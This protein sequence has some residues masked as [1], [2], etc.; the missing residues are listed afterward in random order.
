MQLPPATRRAL[1]PR[2]LPLATGEVLDRHA[3]PLRSLRLSLTD[4]CNLRCSYCMPRDCYGWLPRADLLDFEELER[5]VAVF[6]AQGVRRLRL[7]GGE[8]LLRRDLAGLVARL[9]RQPGLEDLA[10]TTNG[11]LLEDQVAGLAAAGL[12]R[13]TVSLDTLVP[14]RFQALTRRD[15]HARVLRGIAAAAAAPLAELKLNVVVLRGF[16]DDELPDLLAFGRELG[17]EVRFIEYMDVGG[18]TDWR[19]ERVVGREELLA[20]LAA[21]LG[22]LTPLGRE[23]AAATATRF[24]LADGASFGLVTSTTAPFCGDCDR[25]RVTADGQWLRCLYATEALDLRAALRAGASEAELAGLIARVWAA[26]SDRGAEE[27]LRAAARG[28]WR[29]GGE[30]RAEP[31]L[32]MHTRGG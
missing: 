19:P 1:P 5:L 15:E 32:E 7:T 14:E 29:D 22:P 9:A 30:L 26:R 28:P 20:R 3:R 4:R 2:L 21:A 8:P 10:L 12:R 16:N 11:V 6:C 18:A 27:R 24:A 25:S 31:H 17:A 23:R 13:I